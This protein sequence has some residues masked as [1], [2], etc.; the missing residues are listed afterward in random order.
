MTTS[1][2][3]LLTDRKR[4]VIKL[5]GSMLEGLQNGFFKKFHEMKS[6]G[7]EIV[8]VHGGG[9]SINTALRKNAIASNIDNGIRVTCDQSIAIVRDVL[10]G[11]VNPSLVHQLNREGIDAIGLSGFDGKLLIC[12]L[13]DK[14]RYGFV[15]DIQDVNDRLL[16][17]LLAAGIVPVVSC[18]G[19]TE[20][21]EPLNIN[22]DT[23]ASKIALAIGASS[24][25]FVTDTPG[26][27]IGNEIQT[28]VSPG[29]I[30][31]WIEAGDIYGGMIPK[32]IAAIA[33]LDAGV[34]SV[35]IAD[36]HLAGTTIGVEEVII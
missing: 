32:V 36:Q 1:K 25:L 11:E 33:C 6:E 29:E 26:I 22:A 15:G 35:Q 23:V 17:K 10:I 34:P 8:I 4:I 13:L 31:N 3:M 28:V 16:K 20:C 18:I 7:Y 24:L 12:T 14:E 19:A 27:K 30:A 21:G 5:G 2:S 9:P